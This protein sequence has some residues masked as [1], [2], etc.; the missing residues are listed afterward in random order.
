MKLLFIGGTGNISTWCSLRALEAGHELWHLNRGVRSAEPGLE[1]VKT[2]KADLWN[3]ESYFKAITGLHF[4]CVINFMVFS[5]EQA[6]Q[7]VEFWSGKTQQYIFISSASAYQKPLKDLII[8]ESTPL[9]NPFWEYS[10][11]K[12]TCEQ[13]F[14]KAH[15]Q[16]LLPCT[17]VRPSHTYGTIIP[18]ALG[19]SAFTIPARILANKPV[20]IHGDGT[21]LWTLTHSDD[22]AQGLLPLVGNSTALGEAFHIT[23]DQCLTWNEIYQEMALQLDCK[24]NYV[25]IASDFIAERYPDAGAGLLGD[26]SWNARFDNSKLKK[27]N[28]DFN[29]KI[30]FRQGLSQVLKWFAQAPA[31]QTSDP[32]ANAM[33]NDLLDQYHR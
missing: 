3:R 26:K 1:K 14:L 31:R 17:I 28:P 11:N 21:T 19:D 2:L 30:S 24:L 23:S 25:H 20:I 12:I 9:E 8:T 6:Q 16:G 22:F 18:A 32:V 27:I 4:D 15:G 33:I 10:R 7:E 13:I 5:P 29:A